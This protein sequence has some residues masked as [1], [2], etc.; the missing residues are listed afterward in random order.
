MICWYG[1]TSHP[2]PVTLVE[3]TGNQSSEGVGGWDTLLGLRLEVW[4]LDPMK[5]R[6]GVPG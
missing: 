5:P 3:Q 2:V 4:L 6:A 1:L